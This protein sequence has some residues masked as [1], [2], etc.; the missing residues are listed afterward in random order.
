MSL[1]LHPIDV[2]QVTAMATQTQ[3]EERETLTHDCSFPPFDPNDP[4][5]IWRSMKVTACSIARDNEVLNHCLAAKDSE[6]KSLRKR[7][8]S[9]SKKLA[10]VKGEVEELKAKKQLLEEGLC[11]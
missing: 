2:F 9:L 3:L 6:A 7:V 10:L 4:I 8:H 11:S 5:S 1:T